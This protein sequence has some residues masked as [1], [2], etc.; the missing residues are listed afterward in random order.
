MNNCSI[1]VFA[2]PLKFSHKK[3]K[4][5]VFGKKLGFYRTI[6]EYEPKSIVRLTLPLPILLQQS[7]FARVHRASPRNMQTPS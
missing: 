3:Q 1:P 5:R 6:S 2:I 7:L 4:S